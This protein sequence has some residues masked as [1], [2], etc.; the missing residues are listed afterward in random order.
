M[1]RERRDPLLGPSL[2]L[3]VGLH[4]LV[5]LPLL[6]A[7]LTAAGPSGDG[8]L[9]EPA[10]KEDPPPA[11]EE[12]EPPLGIDRS[13]AVTLN[14]IGYEEYAEHLAKLAET[15]QA[16]FIDD[17]AG[18]GGGTAG[19]STRPQGDAAADGPAPAP[20]AR[21]TP[22][23]S[24][25]ASPPGV[26]SMVPA[27][28]KTPDPASPVKAIPG[29][30]PTPAGDPD[31]T[32]PAPPSPTPADADT[33]AEQPSPN[34]SEN[35]QPETPPK[36]PATPPAAPKEG[37]PAPAAPGPPR[38]APPK[39]GD[40]AEKES[41]AFSAID[42]PPELWR[43]G[44]P[45]AM[46]GLEIQTRRPTLPL[47]TQLTTRPRHPVAELRFDRRGKVVQAQLL[48]S[49]GFAQVDGPILDALYNWRAKGEVLASLEENQV[50]IYRIRMVLRD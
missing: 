19:E 8:P 35:P 23:A 26:P 40:A 16:A 37:D 20:P 6:A 24:G 32:D 4:A 43:Q 31:R 13:E 10:P 11:P 38:E 25:G 29:D 39:A 33:P 27:A 44:K 45:L 9:F 2:A 7:T 34:P 21:E 42:V 17:D 47:L 41:D 22:P 28:A 18:G 50:A 49:T 30:D 14:W 5:I 3:S 15:D 48:T 1:R 12:P 46:K 36:A